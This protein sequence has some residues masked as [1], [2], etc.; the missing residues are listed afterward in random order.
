M[1]ALLNA[2]FARL[3]FGFCWFFRRSCLRGCVVWLLWSVVPRQESKYRLSVSRRI[4]TLM[5]CT[6]VCGIAAFFQ[7][8]FGNNENQILI[9]RERE[10]RILFWF[11]STRPMMK[12]KDA[13]DED[14]SI[15]NESSKEARNI[16]LVCC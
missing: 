13:H 6:L 11:L 16:S 5:P 2:S 4:Q 14:D 9:Q 7:K 3:A 1:R 10:F 15:V 12:R 8:C